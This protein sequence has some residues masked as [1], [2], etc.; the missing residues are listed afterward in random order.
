M[1]TQTSVSPP[2][3]GASPILHRVRGK[4]LLLLCVMY[5]ISYL[6]RTNISTAGPTIMGALHLNATQF[7]IA[8]SAFSIPYALLQIF[9]GNLGERF[10]AR[11]SLFWI[12]VLWGVATI[13][14]G[15]SVGLWSLVG[16]RLLLGLTESAAFPT[17]TS[18]MSRWVPPDRNGFAQGV[19]HSASR[20]G[21]AVAPILVGGLI[22]WGDSLDTFLAGWQISF[23]LV[24]LLSV[25]WALMWMISYRDRPQ[26]H[27]KVTEL[28]LSEIPRELEKAARPATPWVRLIRTILPVAIVDF[29]YGWVLWVFLTWIP[30]FLSDTFDLPLSKYA[31][32]TSV[33]LVGGVVG[34]TVGGVFADFL[35]RRTGNLRNSRRTVLL[36]GLIGSMVWLVPL[37][38]GHTLAV[39]TVSLSLSF[40]FLELCNATLWAIPMDVAPE[41]SG[42][43]SGMM[44]TGFGV[45]GI[46]SP[47]VFGAMVDSV[48][49]QWPFGLSIALLAAVAV[50]AAIMKPRRVLPLG[51]DD[52]ADAR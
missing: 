18:A 21:N 39:A 29:G 23:L 1:S 28:E 10:G 36:V 30:T 49:W 14:T 4:V 12:G 6:D 13:A 26:N 17:A 35:L 31:L 44:N 38:F 19:V 27:P 25:I 50:V 16:A 34:D 47:I 8:V 42:T 33:V 5:A 51:V 22:I 7:G 11:K 46:F 41:W 2:K 45:A 3:Q 40:F 20:L 15:F 9:G 37:L 52:V 32:F 24:G 43:A 48:G